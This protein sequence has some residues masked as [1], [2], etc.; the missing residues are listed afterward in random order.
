[1]TY[2]SLG[3]KKTNNRYICTTNRP[4]IFLIKRKKEEPKRPSSSLIVRTVQTVND[5]AFCLPLGSFKKNII[6]IRAAYNNEI[7]RA[8]VA[9]IFDR[10][11]DVC[12]HFTKHHKSLYCHGDYGRSVAPATG[13]PQNRIFRSLE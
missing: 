2:K 1:V 5:K 13:C 10:T 7:I 6:A 11:R 8:R 12:R 3:V 9:A 4:D